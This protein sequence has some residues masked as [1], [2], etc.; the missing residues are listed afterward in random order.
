MIPI[1]VKDQPYGIY[2]KEILPKSSWHTHLKHSNSYTF[3]LQKVKN[4]P[5]GFYTH[6]F[7]SLSIILL[8]IVILLHRLSRIIKVKLKWLRATKT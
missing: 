3:I 6:L 5:D 1:S 4:P 2:F 8:F 7:F